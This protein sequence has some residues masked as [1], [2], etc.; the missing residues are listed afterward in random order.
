MSVEASCRQAPNQSPAFPGACVLAFVRM[1]GE[2]WISGGCET[3]KELEVGGEDRLCG[4][5][6]GAALGLEGDGDSLTL[7]DLN[8]HRT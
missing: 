3:R 8:I 7:N 5:Q 2:V 1:E 4:G 6:R